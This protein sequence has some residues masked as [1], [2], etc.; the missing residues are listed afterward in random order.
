MASTAITSTAMRWMA[1]LA[2]G[3]CGGGGGDDGIAVDAP[4]AI[5]AKPAL[6]SLVTVP[7]A[8]LDGASAYGAPLIVGGQT[9]TVQ[10]DT[11]STITAIADAVCGSQCAGVTPLYKPGSGAVDTKESDSGEY[12][13]MSGWSGEIYTDSGGVTVD[14]QVPLSF[15]GI[16]SQNE[17]FTDNSYQ[18]ILG[19]GP[20]DLLDPGETAYADQLV[21]EGLVDTL[22]FQECPDRG[23]MWLGGFDASATAAPPTYTPMLPISDQGDP[24][25]AVD[26][27]SLGLGSATLG[28]GAAMFG[29]TLV[30]TG[31]SVSFVPTPIATALIAAINASPGFQAL[32]PSQTFANTEQGGCV[33][34]TTV[35]TDQIDAMLPP[36][37]ISWPT[38]DGSAPVPLSVAPS[39]SYMYVD[40]MGDFCLSVIDSGGDASY[41][42]LIGDTLQAAFVTVFDVTHHQIGFAPEA[43]CAAAVAHREAA[44]AT[45]RAGAGPWY[46]QLPSWRGPRVG[47]HAQRQRRP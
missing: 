36:M 31:T 24:F 17:F 39:R 14:S 12:A 45:R 15:V 28:S 7:L 43:G 8:S 38:T 6:P 42:S 16:T 18:G 47:P 30:D 34:S 32:F 26:I 11:G 20:A 46:A 5:D 9:F 37:T 25:Y 13:D 44:P 40:G 10:I 4:A 29:D 27:A 2:L 33:T 35:T 1:V 23:Q 19:L 3:A 21:A 41:G 22:A